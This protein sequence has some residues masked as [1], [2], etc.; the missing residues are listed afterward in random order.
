MNHD[1]RT[2]KDTMASETAGKN[3]GGTI[4]EAW[5]RKTGAKLGGFLATV[6]YIPETVGSFFGGFL[7][8]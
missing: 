6:R 7:H 5:G 2:C 4:G 3:I 8:K 1:T